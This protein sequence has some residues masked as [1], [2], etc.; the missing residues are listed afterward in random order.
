MTVPQ[1]GGEDELPE[2]FELVLPQLDLVLLLLVVPV[3]PRLLQETL[4]LQGVSDL[5]LLAL[6]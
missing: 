6:I 1:A 4:E 5:D 3:L 2:H